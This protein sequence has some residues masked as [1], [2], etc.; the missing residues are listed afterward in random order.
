MDFSIILKAPSQEP[1]RTI[2]IILA[3]NGASTETSLR[4]FVDILS[5]KGASDFISYVESEFKIDSDNLIILRESD[6]KHLT[7][8]ENLEDY[9]KVDDTIYV[10]TKRRIPIEEVEELG[11][12]EDPNFLPSIYESGMPPEVKALI[13]A[14]GQDKFSNLMADLN[15]IRA[16]LHNAREGVAR[17]NRQKKAESIAKKTILLY[18]KEKTP[19][20]EEKMKAWEQ[21]MDQYHT[22]LKNMTAYIDKLKSYPIDDKLRESGKEH[23]LD[24]FNVERLEAGKAKYE[25]DQVK[26]KQKLHEIRVDVLKQI[27]LIRDKKETISDYSITLE[28][29]INNLTNDFDSLHA[30]YFQEYK[31]LLESTNEKP[32]K[33]QIADFKQNGEKLKPKL[34]KIRKELE[35]K[36][37]EIQ[38]HLEENSNQIRTFITE[39]NDL[40]ETISNNISQKLDSFGAAMDKFEADLQNVQI[41]EKFPEVYQGAFPEIQRRLAFNDNLLRLLD[42][43]KKFIDDENKE[44][45]EYLKNNMSYLPKDF[46][47]FL[48]SKF[49]SLS[50]ENIINYINQTQLPDLG[51]A[52]SNHIKKF[53]TG[54]DSSVK[55]IINFQQESAKKDEKISSL[56]KQVRNLQA[57]IENLNQKIVED[58]LNVN[59]LR[60]LLGQNNFQEKIFTQMANQKTKL[61]NKLKELE[62]KL[63]QV[64][65]FGIEN[66]KLNFKKMKRSLIENAQKQNEQQ[67]ANQRNDPESIEDLQFNVAVLTS[68]NEELTSLVEEICSKNDVLEKTI[69]D[70][71]RQ[72]SQVETEKI[73]LQNKINELKKSVEQKAKANELLEKELQEEKAKNQ[74]LTLQL[75]ANLDNEKKAF[76]KKIQELEAERKALLNDLE[77]M[78][79]NFAVQAQNTE[80]IREHAKEE[81]SK[82]EKEIALL[83]ENYNKVLNELNEKRREVDDLK[84]EIAIHKINEEEYK[85]LLKNQGKE[86]EMI[87]ND[88][89]DPTYIKF[90]DFSKGDHFIA[91]RIPGCNELYQAINIMGEADVFYI[92][93]GNFSGKETIMGQI[94]DLEA[95][96]DNNL[97]TRFSDAYLYT[98]HPEKVTPLKSL[99]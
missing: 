84:T 24:Y 64:S 9:L 21:K 31:N 12:D 44:R 78:R 91:I 68:K 10:Y 56:E 35:D 39:I 23:L 97:L 81:I 57:D 42:V 95:C 29:V 86:G 22:M 37:Q 71:Q 67:S 77:N 34:N 49:P 99:K 3:E 60:L 62:K 28:L 88:P 85:E 25:S 79:K 66:L 48:S 51:I 11:L 15:E 96:K 14:D 55:L 59:N 6:G 7:P 98:I 76:E 74:K 75:N 18:L 17:L 61:E 32:S 94:K 36:Q 19:E 45:D 16:F 63:N 1:Q 87:I 5:V 70:A 30:E 80:K 33:Q 47:P 38:K 26:L 53:S 2:K 43:I 46:C 41:L 40:Y 8:T 65:L 13:K 93:K 82:Y 4:K 69:K 52:N 89:N 83:K 73:A 54:A 27:A 92:I 58:G 20:I 72:I 50:T 90:K